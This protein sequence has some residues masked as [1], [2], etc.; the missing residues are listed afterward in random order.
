MCPVSLKVFAPSNG[1]SNPKLQYVFFFAL[2]AAVVILILVVP[3]CRHAPSVCQVFE[4]QEPQRFPPPLP[5]L[6]RS[7]IYHTANK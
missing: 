2:S 6:K 5:V 4:P 3:Q 1:I 7:R